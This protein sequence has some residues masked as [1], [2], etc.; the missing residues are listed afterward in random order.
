MLK[1]LLEFLVPLREIA[2]ELH[3]MRELAELYLAEKPGIHRV[4]QKP[5]ENDVEVTYGY[6]D[7]STL[8]KVRQWFD[9]EA[10][11][12]DQEPEN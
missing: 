4:T 6:Q 2:K 10:E 1:Q 9:K 12:E 7:P 8:T 5:R 3:I 11:P